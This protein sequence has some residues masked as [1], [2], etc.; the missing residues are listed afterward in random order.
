VIT[1]NPLKFIFVLSALLFSLTTFTVGQEKVRLQGKVFDEN[2]AFIAGA[3]VI[4]DDN[5]NH[6]LMT[7][8]DAQG[9]YLFA[10]APLG[11]FTLTVNANGFTESSQT[12]EVKNSTALDITLKI[13]VSERIDVQIKSDNLTAVALTGEKIDALPSDPRQLRLRLQRLANGCCRRK[14][15]FPRF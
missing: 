4:L 12:V 6:K 11:K 5:Q 14:K 8:T 7:I 10:A 15:Q 3:T 2:G 1:Q 13:T 9:Q